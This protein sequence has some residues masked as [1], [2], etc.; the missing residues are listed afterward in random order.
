M[1]E[2]DS[3]VF[4]QLVS[5]YLDEQVSTG[6]STLWHEAVLDGKEVDRSH[7]LFRETQV[8]IL[9]VKCSTAAGDWRAEH[10]RC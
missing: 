3:G 9:C 7:N 1:L 2:F 5:T 8:W 10:S 6:G 4:A